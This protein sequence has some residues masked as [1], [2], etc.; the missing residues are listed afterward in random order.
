MLQRVESSSVIEKRF[1][2]TVQ[3]VLILLMR[4][5]IECNCLVILAIMMITEIGGTVGY[6]ILP[7][8]ESVASVSLGLG[9][10]AIVIHLT[11][12]HT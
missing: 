9:E 3:V 1:L 12:V 5:K 7:Y 10:N 11:L 8:I 6:Q 4:S 2:K